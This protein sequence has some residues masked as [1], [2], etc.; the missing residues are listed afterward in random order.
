MIQ[1]IIQLY[2]FMCI[3]SFIDLSFAK[4]LTY[5]IIIISSVRYAYLLACCYQA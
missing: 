1:G 5:S 3:V 4:L 2:T